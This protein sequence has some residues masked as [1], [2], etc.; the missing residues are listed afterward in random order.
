M[1]YYWMHFKEDKDRGLR[2]SWYLTLSWR[3]S[4]S[5]GWLYQLDNKEWLFRIY[6]AEHRIDINF[7][8]FTKREVMKRCV[9]ILKLLNEMENGNK[10]RKEQC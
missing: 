3:S 9:A 4:P 6:D 10:E 7:K 8:G 2:E 5:S 1:K